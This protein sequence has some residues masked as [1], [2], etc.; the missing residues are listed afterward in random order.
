MAEK[1]FFQK[2]FAMREVTFLAIIQCAFFDS[3][4]FS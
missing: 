2:N 1:L 4:Y 3:K